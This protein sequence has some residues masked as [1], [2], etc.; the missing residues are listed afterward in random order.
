MK[1]TY[2]ILALFFLLSCRDKEP[3]KL[4]Q[5][6]SVCSQESHT[7]INSN[8]NKIKIVQ[9]KGNNVVVINGQTYINGVLQ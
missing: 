2:Y 7:I 4:Q 5:S 3:K 9:S 6:D 8:G 1:Y